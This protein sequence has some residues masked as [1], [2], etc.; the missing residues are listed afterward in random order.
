MWADDGH[1]ESIKSYLDTGDI[2]VLIMI[3][4]SKD[5]IETGRSRMR[6]FRF[7]IY[8]VESNPEIRIGLAFPWK[9][10]PADYE[11]GTEYR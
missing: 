7:H 5:F 9:D 2:D 1:R 10:F 11:N 3:C 8:A 4:C 6:R